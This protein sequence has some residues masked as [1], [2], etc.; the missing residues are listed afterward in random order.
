MFAEQVVVPFVLPHTGQSPATL[1]RVLGRVHP[2][3]LLV[4]SADVAV[5]ESLKEAIP[6]LEG[7]M[8]E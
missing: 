4:F 5:I 1:S 6:A 7:V 8:R 3:T 2:A